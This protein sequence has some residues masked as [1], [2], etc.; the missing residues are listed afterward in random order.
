MKPNVDL[1]HSVW[2]NSREFVSKKEVALEGL[3]LDDLTKSIFTNGPF[4]YFIV[5]FFDMKIN[6]M[7]PSVKDIHGFDPDS[8]VFQDI[9]DEIHPDDM[10]F[11]A[12]AEAAVWDLIFNKI[13]RSSNKKYKVSYCFRLKTRD[14]TYQLFHHQGIILTT[15]E[16]GNIGKS[17]NVHTNIN[18]L[19]AQNNYKVSVIGMLGEPSY[20]DIPLTFGD[21]KFLSTKQLLFSKREI[22]ILKLM[23]GGMI[24]TE[25]ADKLCI[26]I[27][28]V[29]TH[30]KNIMKKGNCKTLAQLI[31]KCVTE[32]V[33][34]Q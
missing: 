34:Q 2:N 9:L 1:L 24:S 16:E 25:I 14:G 13:D 26:S 5:D 23:A 15:D 12:K 17:L 11:V 19:T 20:M 3:T 22:E 6:H 27:N 8:V 30:R 10:M 7:S 31:I 18:H 4:Y 32:G 21:Q 33:I 29:N 28:T